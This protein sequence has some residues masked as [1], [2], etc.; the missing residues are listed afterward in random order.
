[1]FA[2]GGVTLFLVYSE[3]RVIGLGLVKKRM[4]AL[5]MVGER[6]LSS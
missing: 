6:G 5:P 3:L 4:V 1:M 2:R